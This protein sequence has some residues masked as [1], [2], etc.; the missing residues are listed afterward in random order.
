MKTLVGCTTIGSTGRTHRSIN[1]ALQANGELM[2]VTGL[3]ARGWYP[4]QRHTRTTA[5]TEHLDRLH[6]SSMRAW[7]TNSAKRKPTTLPPNMTP[8]KFFNSKSPR[9]ALR[10]V[11]SLLINR[12][13]TMEHT[14]YL[15]YMVTNAISLLI[16]TLSTNTRASR[17]TQRVSGLKSLNPL[18]LCT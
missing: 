5:S 16:S 8:P 14:L 4:K 6:Q 7:E 9:D 12:K 15:I 11:T 3:P 13:G 18:R 2:R 1:H 10:R 17:L